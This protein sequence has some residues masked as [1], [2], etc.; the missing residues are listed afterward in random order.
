[1]CS[2]PSCI[3]TRLRHEIRNGHLCLGETRA[4][5]SIRSEQERLGVSSE[6]IYT[7]V[8]VSVRPLFCCCYC[9]FS[10]E[11]QGCPALGGT[12]Q[13]VR[14]GEVRHVS[15]AQHQNHLLTCRCHTPPQGRTRTKREQTSPACTREAS[16]SLSS[17]QK[18][19]GMPVFSR[20]R[21]RVHKAA[22]Q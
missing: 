11:T 2:S 19:P 16:S 13:D 5:L 14:R 20:L 6:V 3:Y 15:N 7:L 9:I 4:G 17:W 21:S 10:T 1:M 22:R 18:R 12:G 8:S